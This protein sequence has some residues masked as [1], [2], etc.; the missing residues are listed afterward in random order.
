[1]H[2]VVILFSKVNRIHGDDVFAER[3]KSVWVR[4]FVTTLVD[5]FVGHIKRKF[6]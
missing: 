4:F 5:Q 2:R 3:T 1:V 6:G